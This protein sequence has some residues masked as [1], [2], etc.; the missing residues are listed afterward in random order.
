MS[1]EVPIGAPVYLLAG[2]SWTLG[3]VT[4]P[5]S[6]MNGIEFCPNLSINAS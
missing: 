2:R 4:A 1:Y 3:G 5:I 6:I